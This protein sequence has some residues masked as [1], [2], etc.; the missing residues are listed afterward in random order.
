MGARPLCAGGLGPQAS[1]IGVVCFANDSS[2]RGGESVADLLLAAHC[3]YICGAWS[4]VWPL[5]GRT[6]S[7]CK[8]PIWL[9]PRY[10]IYLAQW[11][12]GLLFRYSP[13]QKVPIHSKRFKG[14]NWMETFCWPLSYKYKYM[15]SSRNVC[16]GVVMFPWGL[17]I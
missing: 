10:C 8:V 13:S 7:L 4:I 5:S 9:G 2:A 16:Y 15:Q 1:G 17:V 14:T 3:L 12:A 6:E 11:L